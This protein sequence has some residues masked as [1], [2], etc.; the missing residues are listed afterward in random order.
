ME[1]NEITKELR[2]YKV[3]IDSDNI[4]FKE[5]IKK[6]LLNNEA[7]IYALNNKELQD[8]N[9]TPDEYYGVNI[10]PYYMINQTQTNVQN[11]ICYEVSY[12]EV[13]AY[14]NTLKY[15]QII[16][17]ILCE[18]KNLI[19]AKTGIAR[20]DLLAALLMEEF[21][22]KNCFGQQVHCISDKPSVVDTDYASR[23]LIFQ[24]EIPNN[25]VKT[26]DKIPYIINKMDNR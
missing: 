2:E 6:A 19:D 7:I 13:A 21:N 26:R 14:N 10:L 24:M 17:Y 23:T 5:V 4:R 25:I 16:F 8:A 22:W 12:D 1:N 3:L 20:H 15:G 9:A 18:Q 11:F